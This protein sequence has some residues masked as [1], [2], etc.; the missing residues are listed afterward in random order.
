MLGA[1][2]LCLQEIYEERHIS[3]ISTELERHGYT[4]QRPIP[5]PQW[6]LSCGLLVASRLKVHGAYWYDFTHETFDENAFAKRGIQIV[7]VYWPVYGDIAIINVHLTA[8]GLFRHPE[9][10]EIDAIRSDQISQILDLVDQES[11]SMVVIAGDINS[12]PGVSHK[13]YQQFI[14][15]GFI[16]TALSAKI[17]P[18]NP[19]YTW[20]PTNLLAK[21]GPHA[22][23][24]PQRIDHVLILHR[25]KQPLTTLQCQIHFEQPQVQVLNHQNVTLSDHFCVSADISIP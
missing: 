16:D 12:G 20:I 9:A 8:G 10:L 24:P 2:L 5:G 4:I 3:P 13:N 25:G 6:Q 7:R 15:Y 11:A 17:R 14:D 22:S 19:S 21:N 23:S 1:D 18:K